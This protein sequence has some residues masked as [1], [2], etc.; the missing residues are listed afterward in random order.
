MILHTRGVKTVMVS[1][2][3]LQRSVGHLHTCGD[4]PLLWAQKQLSNI[5]TIYLH[6]LAY[7]PPMLAHR[8]P[9]I[10]HGRPRAY[11]PQAPPAARR[12]IVPKA[13][14]P[15]AVGIDLGTSNSAVAVIDQNGGACMVL[16]PASPGGG[17][18][19]P[20]LVHY[21][22]D[23]SVLVGHAAQQVCVCVSLWERG[24]CVPL[25]GG[26]GCWGQSSAASMLLRR[27]FGAG[28]IPALVLPD[29][30]P[31]LPPPPTH[32]HDRQPH[33]H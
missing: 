14:I 31:A 2:C 4:G 13:A 10:L 3:P 22:R 28:T 16:D 8:P 5:N 25:W 15:P 27:H 17:F 12:L 7:C 33:P 6:R 11:R 18:T 21:G 26:C 30:T 19:V 32:A 23:G 20:S 29:L 24:V 9:S 1:G